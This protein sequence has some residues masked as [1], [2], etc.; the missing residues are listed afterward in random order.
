MRLSRRKLEEEET[1]SINVSPLIDVVFILLIFFIVSAT[2][3]TL[4]GVEVNRPQAKTAEALEKNS[5]LFA[6][7]GKNEIFHGGRKVSLEAVPGLIENASR[8]RPKPV[9]IQVDR[10][11][12][13]TLMAKLVAKARQKA[14]SVSLATRKGR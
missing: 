5:V 11:S 9:V 10:L 4:P 1:G 6:L 7:S 8:D 2:F 12:D 13:A 14:P 3:V